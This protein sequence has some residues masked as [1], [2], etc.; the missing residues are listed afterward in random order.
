MP[1]EK[2]K[3]RFGLAA[4][5]AV[6]IKTIQE[7]ITKRE[8]GGEFTDI[9]DFSKRIDPKSVNKK[10]IEAF[11]KS[12]TF[13]SITD[14]RRQIHESYELLNAYCVQQHDEANSNQM[15][16]FGELIDEE[17]SKPKL[18]QVQDW[19]KDERLLREFQAFGFFLLEHPLDDHIDVLRKRGCVF[20]DKITDDEFE[21]GDE[22]KFPGVIASTKHRSSPRGRFAYATISDPYGI[23][24]IMIFDEELI[25]QKRDL[26]ED[27]CQVLI[28]CMVRK[29]EG[30]IRI[31][32]KGIE[33]L[34]EFIAN[35]TEE[36]D[37]FEDIKK[38]KFRK[39]NPNAQ[40]GQG[41]GSGGGQ[42]WQKKEGS[43]GGGYG[44]NKGDQGGGGS[45][46]G[47]SS[48]SASNIIKAVI[49]ADF[50]AIEIAVNKRE[51]IHEIKSFLT[52]RRSKGGSGKTTK[53]VFVISGQKI[54]LPDK[55]VIT[56][57]DKD[58]L[59]TI[60]SVSVSTS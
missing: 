36:D 49:E 1:P 47:G 60:E 51:S 13:D 50:A 3:I 42:K 56:Q 16:F 18:K 45:S 27:G 43:Q 44:G 12:G 55:Y 48:S 35:T 10:S 2:Y 19:D 37:P 58:K 21:D 6:G 30:G 15:T 9:F 41:G 57:I 40:Q 25:T 14:N 26:L 24:E 4:I 31:L 38:N 59:E 39:K 32:S 22:V 34:E 17:K 28:R 11:A 33:R 8:E 53:V 23:Y 5:K 46:Q 54:E 52:M 20:S 29:D 7:I